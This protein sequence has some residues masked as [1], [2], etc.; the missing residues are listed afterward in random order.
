MITQSFYCRSFSYENF[1]KR[2][3][4]SDRNHSRGIDSSVYELLDHIEHG[5][6]KT[7]KEYPR[8]IER[9]KTYL[10]KGVVKV[11][12]W[13]LTEDERRTVMYYARRIQSTTDEEV[14]YECINGLL[15]TTQRF[16]DY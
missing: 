5:R 14:L 11:L 10:D 1:M 9:I 13:R 4:R 3:F 8:Q 6:Y 7:V 2:A 15:E 12:K 16:R